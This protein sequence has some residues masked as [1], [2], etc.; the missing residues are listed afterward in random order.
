MKKKAEVKGQ[1][2]TGSL[3]ALS[4]QLLSIIHSGINSMKFLLQLPPPSTKLTMQLSHGR[5]GPGSRPEW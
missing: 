1:K 5:F 4:L 2:D 3:E